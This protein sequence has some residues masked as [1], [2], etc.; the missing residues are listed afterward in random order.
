LKEGWIPPPPNLPDGG[1]SQHQRGDLPRPDAAAE[2]G[3]PDTGRG[4]RDGEVA[5]GLGVSGVGW[6]VARLWASGRG[7]HGGGE[8]SV[9]YYM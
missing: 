7:G 9:I 5:A 2:E 3:D 1:V 6:L 8:A 4:E